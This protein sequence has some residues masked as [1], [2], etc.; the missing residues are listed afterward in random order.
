MSSLEI[1]LI[2]FSCLF[3]SALFGL[4]LAAKL[5]QHHLD[6]HSKEAIKIGAGLIATLTALVLGLLVSSAKSSYDSMNEELTQASATLIVLDRVLAKYGDETKPIRE[7]LKQNLIFAHEQI[8]PSEARAKT[9]LQAVEKKKGMEA[10]RD[11]IMDLKPQNDKQR[12]LLQEAEAVS[13]DLSHSRW[14]LIEHERGVLP[15]PFL[16]VLVFWLAVFFITFGL[17]SP[18]NGTIVSLMFV[19]T[20]SVA[21][22]IFLILELNTP[23]EGM[24]KISDAAL[25][26]AL[27]HLST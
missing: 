8:W 18:V 26:K 6:S 1:S 4:L 27:Q 25:L 9:N 24:I 15:T 19:C 20:V 10:V 14:L 3:G 11:K 5:P 23:L 13:T 12:A 22:A 2:A 21:G 16:V 17:L 7:M